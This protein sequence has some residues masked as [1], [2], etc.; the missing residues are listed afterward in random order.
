[1]PTPA[2]PNNL[3]GSPDINDAG[4][5][6]FRATLDAGGAG[7]FTGPDAVNDRVIGTGDALFGST[8]TDVFFARG[9]NE[10][11]SLAFAYTLANGRQGVAL[12]VVPE[13]VA[14]TLLA[15]AALLLRGRGRV[16]ARR[17]GKAIGS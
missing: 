3:L 13:P 11:G 1:L 2:A 7:I 12:A 9:L 8:V 10:D 16:C 4:L 5:V 17:R 14:L 6:A 15:T